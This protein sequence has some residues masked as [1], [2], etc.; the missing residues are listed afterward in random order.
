MSVRVKNHAKFYST[1]N[2]PFN[3]DSFAN[4][5]IVN[6]QL[7][8]LV[9]LQNVIVMSAIMLIVKEIGGFLRKHS[10]MSNSDESSLY[11]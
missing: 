5:D 1:S 2:V 11:G 8:L 3:V 10:L 7:D 9:V 4:L 6:V